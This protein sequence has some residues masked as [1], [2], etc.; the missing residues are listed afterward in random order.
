[1]LSCA[2]SPH[3][4]GAYA[5][6]LHA[7]SSAIHDNRVPVAQAFNTPGGSSAMDPAAGLHQAG[8]R[9][10]NL[11]LALACL[12]RFMGPSSSGDMAVRILVLGG[13]TALASTPRT[14]FWRGQKPT[15][16]LF[17]CL[18]PP[19]P[20][21]LS[22]ALPSLGRAAVQRWGAAWPGRPILPHSACRN[23]AQAR[24]RAGVGRDTM[25]VRQKVTSGGQQ[26]AHATAGALAHGRPVDL[27][28]AARPR[29]ADLRELRRQKK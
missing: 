25:R 11:R 13:M 16:M 5:F 26:R 23:A 1:M 24:S 9:R 21:L 14:R 28:C 17:T 7:Q 10:A 6:S 3:E 8:S 20:A 12:C 22:A 27:P 18:Y 19:S 29:L 4:V 15:T 2:N